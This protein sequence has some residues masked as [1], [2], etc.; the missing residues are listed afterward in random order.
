MNSLSNEAQQL[1]R[2]SDFGKASNDLLQMENSSVNLD[3]LQDKNL[4][5]VHVCFLCM[6]CTFIYACV[7]KSDLNN[8]TTQLNN[9]INDPGYFQSLQAVNNSI[10]CFLILLRTHCN[11]FLVTTDLLL[12]NGT[13][14]HTFYSSTNVSTYLLKE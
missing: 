1:N 2:T 5:Q 14:I 11:R 13:T 3:Y 9:T 6:A 10:L 12:S 8:V 7:F 4:T